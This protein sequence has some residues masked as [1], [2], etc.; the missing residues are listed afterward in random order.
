MTVTPWSWLSLAAT[1]GML[2]L[3]ACD[4][5]LRDFTVELPPRL[6]PGSPVQVTG[7]PLA[8]RRLWL[9]SSAGDVVT[10]ELDTNPLGAAEVRGHVSEQATLQP[11]VRLREA[12]LA[13]EGG[14][15]S[16]CVPL[17]E[18]VPWRG[19]QWADDPVTFMPPQDWRYGRWAKLSA[20]D[21][22]LAGEGRAHLEVEVER[23]GV[24]LPQATTVVIYNGASASGVWLTPDWLGA[25]PGE[26]R[27]RHRLVIVDVASAVH[28]S[29]WSPWTTR[30]LALPLLAQAGVVK[31]VSLSRGRASE[32]L[33][34]DAIAI[35]RSGRSLPG[36]SWVPIGAWNDDEATV[37]Q[38]EQATAT[39]LPLWS[40]GSAVALPSSRWWA[41]G[42][43]AFE[44]RRLNGSYVWRLE[45]PD[46]V[47]LSE[48]AQHSLTIEV[49][50][51]VQAVELRF[52]DSAQVGLQAFGLDAKS[53]SIAA[54]VVELVQQHFDGLRLKIQA[55]PFAHEVI[56]RV[57]VAVLDR[58]PNGMN[59]LGNDPTVGKDVGNRIMDEDLSG[60]RDRGGALAGQPPY[61]GVFL[62]GM[63]LFS[64]TLNPGGSNVDQRFDEVFSPISP[65]LGAKQGA[66]QPTDEAV[67]V[68][69]QLIASTVSHELGHA[70][71]LASGPDFHH[72][73]D[74]PGWRM[75]AGVARPFAE[76]ANLPGSGGE[77]WGP[78][79][80]I[81]LVESL[82]A[83]P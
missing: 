4:T 66:S 61:G 59:L 26:L 21:L 7:L 83:L 40:R 16:H 9:C 73:G 11:G 37:W 23:Q 34:F 76:R 72:Q 45:G 27:L 60:G 49:A 38:P 1:V 10:V 19:A 71:G 12:C 18:A 29:Q 54:R 70:F 22:P 75:D 46:G 56:E 53:E 30:T 82:G 3:S 81:A 78:V 58:D 25:T 57:L 68:M 41:G 28:Q 67:E 44:G 64:P 69:S 48:P 35:D 80:Q 32:S 52:S 65:A 51:S 14:R 42:W 43:R 77:R 8:G 33:R 62:E 17:S 55:E 5:R 47:Y 2:L 39:G 15:P 31:E 20:D 63:L 36:I 74:N 6:R 24:P 50:P 79:D 13:L